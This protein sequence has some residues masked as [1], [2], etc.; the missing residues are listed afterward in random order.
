MTRFKTK[1]LFALISLIMIV[2]VAVGLLLGQL[3]KN[4]YVQSFNERIKKETVFISHYIEEHGGIEPFL[5]DGNKKELASLLESNFTILSA[6]GEIL[7]DWNNNR[8]NNPDTH[9]KV[10]EK[11]IENHSLDNTEGFEVA[12]GTSDLHYY[13]KDIRKNDQIEGYVVLSYEIDAIKKVNRQMWWILAVSLGSCLIVII[14]LGSQIASRYTRPIEA[15]AHT[16]MQLAK[17]NYRARTYE[18]GSGETGMLSTSLNILARNLQEMEIATEMQQDRLVTLIENIG[19]G[20]LLIDNKG[21]I[22][23]INKAYKDIFKVDAS[24]FL[25]RVYYEVI[26]HKKIIAFIEEIF[27]TEQ[28]FK[29]QMNIPLSF[30]RR[31]FEVYGAPIIG[32]NDEWKGILVVFHDITELKR[33]EQMRKDF[34]AN[35]SHELKT[36]ITSIKGFSETLLDGALHDEKTLQ[37]FLTIIL[38]ESDRLQQLIQELLELSKLE[39]QDFILNLTS[40][41]VT[42]LLKESCDILQGRAAEK[43]IKVIQEIPTA[44]VTI[45]GDSY[46][47]K[48]VFL[49]LISNALNYTPNGG[50]VKAEIIEQKRD[51]RII[52]SDTGIGIE[53]GELPRIFERFYRVDKARSRN[54]GG[55]GLGLAIVKH[56]VEA[57]KG[58]IHVESE[59][60]KGTS[61]TLVLNKRLT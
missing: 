50:Q 36:P 47:V 58:R 31:N 3:F 14:M 44:P 10:L 43:G 32:N 28:S 30:E 57:H 33:L 15:A 49:N 39:Q 22:T 20:V 51:V 55:T 16:A 18:K 48:Q 27:I 42:S 59:P 26:E 60:G 13:W 40:L 34:V 23:L 25:Y 7:L 56:I 61:F 24:D 6:K 12:E 35:V 54:S 9:A 45:E 38:K 37:H 2:L 46:R 41:N 53:K 8:K 11:I 4:Y 21:Y 52:I 17:G 5:R 29:R 1:L 19:S